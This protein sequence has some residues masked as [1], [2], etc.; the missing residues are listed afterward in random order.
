MSVSW[1]DLA[2]G[3]GV[4]LIVGAYLFLQLGRLASASLAYS[5]VNGAGA[6]L[7]LISLLFKFNLPAF[8]IEVFWIVISLIGIVK[9]LRA[10]RSDS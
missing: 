3:V 1:P 4:A 9:V 10:R 5:A 2:G 8:V 6:L 7:I